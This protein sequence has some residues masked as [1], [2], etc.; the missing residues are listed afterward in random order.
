MRE[1]KLFLG[2]PVQSPAVE[3]R[4]FDVPEFSSLGQKNRG[5]GW[6]SG[7]V[8]VGAETDGVIE[9]VDV[10]M[11]LERKLLLVGDGLEVVAMIQLSIQ[12]VVKG[13]A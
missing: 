1:K 12:I 3:G 7:I 6:T 2:F 5:D 9:S 11:G 13:V 10:V 4:E 8:A